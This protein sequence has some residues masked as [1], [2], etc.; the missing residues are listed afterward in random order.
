MEFSMQQWL[1]ICRFWWNKSLGGATGNYHHFSRTN[2]TGL[3]TIVTFILSIWLSSNYINSVISHVMT[4]GNLSQKNGPNLKPKFKWP[5]HLKKK[6]GHIFIKFT[7]NSECLKLDHFPVT[8]RKP[9]IYLLYSKTKNAQ[10]V[11]LL[12]ASVLTTPSKYFRAWLKGAGHLSIDAYKY[13]L[14]S[15]TRS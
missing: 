11:L 13:Q 5:M 8:D 3:W 14:K 4:F 1:S 12:G 6:I 15:D 10:T 2:T 9:H 7:E